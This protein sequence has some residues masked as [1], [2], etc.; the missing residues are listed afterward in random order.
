M[1]N[2]ELMQEYAN[3]I[4]NLKKQCGDAGMSEE[5][6]KRMY[7]RS[8]KTLENTGRPEVT[9][10]CRFVIKF[11]FLLVA[12]I[13]GV[14]IVL[15]HNT[16]YSSIVCNLQEYI[17]PGLKLLRKISIPLISL[18][19]SLTGNYNNFFILIVTHNLWQICQ[20]LLS[21]QISTMRHVWSKTHTL[22]WWIWTAG[23]A[24]QWVTSEKWVL[25]SQSAN[26]KLHLSFMR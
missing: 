3:S 13:L 15:N 12:I 14:Y 18:F 19:P 23:R 24:A 20:I 2:Q 26:N 10:P 17:Y 1:S 11:G 4:K 21:F 5:E 22:L 6:F 25:P 7:F 8:L 16:I 9:T